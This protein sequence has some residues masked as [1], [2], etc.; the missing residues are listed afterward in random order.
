[1]QPTIF[2]HVPVS[3]VVEPDGSITI[4]WQPREAPFV[5]EHHDVYHAQMWVSVREERNR[6]LAECDWVA[7]RALETATPVPAEWLTYRQALRDITKQR[8]PFLVAW[9]TKPK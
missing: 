8:N 9:P 3:Q 1:M 6:L 2:T 4:E 5:P 7:A